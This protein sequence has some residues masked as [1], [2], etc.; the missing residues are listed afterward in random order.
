M[1]I[2]FGIVGL[3]LV[4]SSG[5]SAIENG[6]AVVDL[7]PSIECARDVQFANGAA[8][9]AVLRSAAERGDVVA[10]SVLGCMYAKGTGVA[11]NDITAFEYFNRIADEHEDDPPDRPQARLVAKAFVAIGQYLLAGIPDTPIKPDPD[12]ARDMFAHAAAYFH[13]ADAQ[14]YLA[15][16]YLGGVGSIANPLYASRWLG[17]AANKGQHRAQAVL[18]YLLFSGSVGPR[19]PAFGLMWLTIAQDSAGPD[20]AWIKDAY[21]TAFAEA[22]EQERATAFDLL[23]RFMRRRPY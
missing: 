13:D 12:R 14:Y 19:R 1:R 15:C 6:V 23:Q 11:R 21:Q 4:G 8:P 7:R 10:L 5:A 9:L 16:L 20:E 2:L 17:L 3:W 22:S 18:G